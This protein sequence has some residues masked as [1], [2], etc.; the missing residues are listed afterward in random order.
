MDFTCLNEWVFCG[1]LSDLNKYTLNPFHRR[2]HEE[3]IHFDDYKSGESYLLFSER[4]MWIYKSCVDM[5]R[6][7]KK[8][9]TSMLT[10]NIEKT[11][12]KV[13]WTELYS[14]LMKIQ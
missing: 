3:K 2:S 4:K 13:Q 9:Y 6:N 11:P 1:R 7:W 8:G 12:E 14:F 5:V 10:F